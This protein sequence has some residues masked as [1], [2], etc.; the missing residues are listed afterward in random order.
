MAQALS[1]KCDICGVQ[2]RSVKEAQDHGDATGHAAF[3]ESTEAVRQGVGRGCSTWWVCWRRHGWRVACCMGV[4]PGYYM[5]YEYHSSL[6]HGCPQ[7]KRLVCKECGKVRRQSCRSGGVPPGSGCIVL[8]ASQALQ[9]AVACQSLKRHPL[10]SP[11]HGCRPA[12]RTQSGTSTA[13]GRGMQLMTT[14]QALQGGRAG[15]WWQH[16]MGF[17]LDLQLQ[18]PCLP[19]SPLPAPSPGNSCHCAMHLTLHPT[20]HLP[21]TSICATCSALTPNLPCT[22]PAD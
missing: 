16:G 17:A 11:G 2:L 12:A 14:R 22:C 20:L 8:P 18:R 1:L 10:F 6:V 13:S 21:C 19:H 5:S 9:H 3:S 4:C 7:V 15:D